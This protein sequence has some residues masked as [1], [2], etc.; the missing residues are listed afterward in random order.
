MHSVATKNRVMIMGQSSG[1]GS[2]STHLVTKPSFGLFRYAGL[3]SGP[4]GTWISAPM[5]AK[6]PLDA[7]A[8]AQ[9]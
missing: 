3:L 1:A 7:S 5:E 2:V 8:G 6:A 9:A 4:F